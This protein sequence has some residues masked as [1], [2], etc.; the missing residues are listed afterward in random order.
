MLHQNIQNVTKIVKQTNYN[1]HA[2]L[3]SLAQFATVIVCQVT[4]GNTQKVLL[5]NQHYI[6]LVFYMRH[7]QH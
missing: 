2:I 1:M 6:Y 3:G 7:G 5:C 4:L